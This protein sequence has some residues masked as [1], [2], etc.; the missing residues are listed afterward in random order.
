MATPTVGS[1]FKAFRLLKSFQSSTEWASCAELG[2]RSGLSE[3]GAHRMVQTLAEVGVVVR[4]A[5]GSCRLNPHFSPYENSV[6]R[7]PTLRLVT[8]SNR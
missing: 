8:N 6:D 1:V 3:A 5:R 4:N 2:R 7:A